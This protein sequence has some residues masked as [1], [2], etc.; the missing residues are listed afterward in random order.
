MRVEV[1][2]RTRERTTGGGLRAL[3]SNAHLAVGFRQF[4]ALIGQGLCGKKSRQTFLERY[5]SW[6][7]LV[8]SL[9]GEPGPRARWLLVM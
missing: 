8:M 2:D 1:K 5:R 7:D 3:P 4:N 9:P 6:Q